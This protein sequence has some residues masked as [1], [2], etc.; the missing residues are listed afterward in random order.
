MLPSI[1]LQLGQLAP[2]IALLCLVGVLA[3]ASRRS[4]RQK[5]QLISAVDHMSQ[6]LCMY[7]GNER[8]ILCNKRYIEMYGLS[9][10]VVRPGRTLLEVLEYR[11][12]LGSLP[13]TAEEYRRA[14]MAALNEGRTANNVVDSGNG[15]RIYV[16][17]RPMP[18]GGWLGTHED[19]TEREQLAKERDEMAAREK[20]RAMVEAAITAFRERMNGLL[21]TVDGSADAM[22]ATASTLSTSSNDTSERARGAVNASSQA[23]ASVRTAALAAD[24]L[25][26]SIAEIGRQLELTN[27]VVQAAVE[28]AKAT[29]GQIETLAIAAQKIGDVVKLIRDIAGQT[30]LLAL[31]ATIEAARA[32]EAGRG[33]AVVASEV[34]TLAVQTAKATEDIA[35]QI[36]GVQ[37]STTEAVEAIRRIADRMRE[38]NKYTSAV[39][40]S[41][42][43]QSAATG[44]IS[45]NVTHAA[46]E[47]SIV[48]SVLGKVSE[49]ATHTRASA[50]AV[51]DGSQAVEA[52]VSEL[53]GEVENF[54]HKVVS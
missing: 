19:I 50:N 29:D 45:S 54:L 52:A 53:R 12:S 51:L 4:G 1:E 13:G 8:L 30:N 40:A 9:S 35:A 17:N 49:A 46:E 38:I 7:D 22:K 2:F 10:E 33:F 36:L 15:R 26:T 44:Q 6:G 28:E 43:Q 42:E 5:R 37:S 18:G 21:R 27:S 48:G 41:M 34:K 47:T 20:R 14:L 3:V 11:A 32:G 24:E 25:I 39:A 23:T 16:I 31:N